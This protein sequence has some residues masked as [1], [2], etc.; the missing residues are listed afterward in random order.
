MSVR[1]ILLGII[2]QH[3]L[4]NFTINDLKLL[5]KD[6]ISANSNKLLRTKIYKQVW[7]FLQ[8]GILIVN[9]HP[10]EPQKNTYALNNN[11]QGLLKPINTV[12]TQT[13]NATKIKS[14]LETLQKKLGDYSSALASASAEAQE[15]LELSQELPE[16]IHSLQSKFL[17]AKERAVMY[18]GRLS[19]VENVIRDFN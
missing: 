7:L 15:Y 3:Q 5:S 9:K 2:H 16:L 6:H 12:V 14:E 4:V 13:F 19:A 1:K 17:S 8:E 18:Q 10:S 11:S